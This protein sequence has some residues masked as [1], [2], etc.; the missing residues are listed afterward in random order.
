MT[1]ETKAP[2]RRRGHAVVTDPAEMP[3]HPLPAAQATD[4]LQVRTRRDGLRDAGKPIADAGDGNRASRHARVTRADWLRVAR[5][6]L[7]SDGVQSVK[8][9]TIGDRLGVS[10]SSFYWYFQS[11]HDLL[12][13]LLAV[14]EQGNTGIL[15]A[16]AGMPA[17]TI[18]AALANVF[19]CVVDPAGFN[20]RLDFA[21]REWA[22]RD[23]VVRQVI[24][25]SDAARHAAI[26]AMFE[27][28]GF[29]ADEA[30]IRARVVYYQ[31]LGYYA[32][33]LAEPLEER[34]SRVEGYLFCFTGVR[35]SAAE[36]AEFH[37][38]ARALA[39]A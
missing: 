23:P 31:Q 13:Q 37:A 27:R 4:R 19:R 16:H 39:R 26:S 34:L 24:D 14:W 22:R 28:H 38:F 7:I 29:A 20:H 36:V 18:T 2:P 33:E 15:I 17:P 21:V 10:R 6:L 3:C 1:L 9:L 35:P 25:R 11:R 30:D 8:I 5:D 32:L 12:C